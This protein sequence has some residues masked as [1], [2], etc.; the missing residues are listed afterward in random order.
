MQCSQMYSRR[1]QCTSILSLV[2]GTHIVPNRL[3]NANSIPAKHLAIMH[4]M[5]TLDQALLKI[6]QV[7]V[8]PARVSG[9]L[10]IYIR[11]LIYFTGQQTENGR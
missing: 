4:A 2:C 10:H 8:G 9:H 1:H 3:R 11:C 5:H 7:E 6:T